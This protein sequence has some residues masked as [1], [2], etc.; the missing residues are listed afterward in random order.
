VNPPADLEQADADPELVLVWE[1]AVARIGYRRECATLPEPCAF[2]FAI[3]RT[4]DGRV[5]AGYLW[6]R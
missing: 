3:L 2:R 6:E 1:S 4:G 5:L